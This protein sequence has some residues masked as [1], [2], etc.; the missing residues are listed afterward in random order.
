MYYG[1]PGVP[2]LPPDAGMTVPL[3]QPKNLFR[4]GEQTIWSA[5]MHIGGAVIA[6]GTFRLFTT[7]LGQVGQ[8]FTRAMSI[9]ETNL[10]EGGRVPSG[11]AYDVFGLAVQHIQADGVADAAGVDLD[12]PI[13]TAAD[14]GNLVNVLNNG[15][16][17]WDFTQTQVDIA[18]MHLVGSGG[19]VYGSLAATTTAGGALTTFGHHNNGN[20]AMWL[21]RKHP[22][23]LPGNSTFAIVLRYGSRAEDVVT[24][25][26]VEK[27]I[28]LGYYKNVIEIG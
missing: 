12:V 8:G 23:A 21:Y 11:V 2:L 25:S 28:L 15:V 22:V 1:V 13:N 10:K 16:L 9:A 18:P 4:Y 17:S 6:N 20:G 14:M 3:E 5:Q 7:P 26:I 19:G 27:V 24:N